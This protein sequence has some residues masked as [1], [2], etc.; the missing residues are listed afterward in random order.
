MMRERQAQRQQDYQLD[1]RRVG[2]EEMN[3]QA[4][5]GLYRA[6]MANIPVKNQLDQ[7]KINE[8]NRYHDVLQ[9]IAL[10]KLANTERD[11]TSKQILRG[12]RILFIRTFKK[13]RWVWIVR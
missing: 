11:T 12:Q 10:G 4:H 2:A 8:A 6:Q 7:D 1:L 5:S 3:A 13:A 9:N